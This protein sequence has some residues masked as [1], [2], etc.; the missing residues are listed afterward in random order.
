MTTH[1]PNLRKISVGS[2][3]EQ[4]LH[5]SS[6]ANTNSIHINVAYFPVEPPQISC[7][8]DLCEGS[9]DELPEHILDDNLE[10]NRVL[11]VSTI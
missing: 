10:E 8:D 3:P 11:A 7:S 2:E 1:N 6:A 4:V 9:L 5:T